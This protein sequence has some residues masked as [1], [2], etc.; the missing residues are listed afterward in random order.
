VLQHLAARR[1]HLVLVVDR[2][3]LP[4][5]TLHEAEILDAFQVLGPRAPVE[6]VLDL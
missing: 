2:S 1:Y 3:L 5:G 4:V 6:Q